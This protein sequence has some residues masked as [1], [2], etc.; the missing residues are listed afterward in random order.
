MRPAGQ[1]A[2]PFFWNRSLARN[3]NSIRLNRQWRVC[4]VWADQWPANVEI[5]GYH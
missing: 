3:S 1:T 4:F 2:G 5:V